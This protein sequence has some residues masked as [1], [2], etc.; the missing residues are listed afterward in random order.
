[1]SRPPFDGD[2][3]T[4]VM[5]KHLSDPPPAPS[6]YTSGIPRVIDQLVMRYLAKDAEQRFTACELAAA[7]EALSAT[8]L[9]SDDARPRLCAGGE[10]GSCGRDT[11][12]AG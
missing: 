7:I 1:M 4:A 9:Y 2:E 3:S 5:A 12:R 10:H 8:R 6:L 11:K